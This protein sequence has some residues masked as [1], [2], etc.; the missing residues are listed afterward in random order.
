METTAQPKSEL[1]GYG[2]GEL[3]K[4]FLFLTASAVELNVDVGDWSH[5]AQT[6]G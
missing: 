6:P 5:R 1:Q 4:R 2:S 3:D